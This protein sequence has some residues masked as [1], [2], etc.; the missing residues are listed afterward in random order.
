MA[1]AAAKYIINGHSFSSAGL[2]AYENM[3]MS[4]NAELALEERKIPYTNHFS[5]SIKPEDIERADIILT[6][7]SSHKAAFGGL[8][9][10]KVFTLK[11][12]S[13]GTYGDIADP[14]GGDLEEYIKCLDEITEC[15]YAL[16][17][18]LK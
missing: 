15:I 10:D 9:G 1:E 4:R 2:M 12:Y 11:E 5:R 13:L 17:E 3:P 16:K 7:S 6:M 18:R 14:F 8:A